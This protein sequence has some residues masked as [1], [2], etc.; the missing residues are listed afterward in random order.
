[1]GKLLNEQ[2]PHITAQHTAAVAA[3]HFT[4]D[5]NAHLLSAQDF[6]ATINEMVA[7]ASEAVTKGTGRNR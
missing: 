1:M 5:G 2:K 6:N 4:E 3:N 7:R